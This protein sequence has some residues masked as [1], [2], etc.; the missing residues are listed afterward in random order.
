MWYRKQI[1]WLIVWLYYVITL[2]PV[3]GLVQIGDQAAAD[4]YTYLSMIPFYMLIGAGAGKFLSNQKEQKRLLP[5]FAIILVSVLVTV[6]LVALTRQ[7]SMVWRNDLVFWHYTALHAPGSGL[8]R[9]NYGRTLYDIGH[10]QEA[11]NEL[12]AAA[13]LRQ[14]ATINKWLGDAYFELGDLNKAKYYYATSFRLIADK[15]YV[16]TVEV[17]AQLAKI[18][19]KQGDTLLAQK[20]VDEALRLDPANSEARQLAVQLNTEK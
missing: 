13:E 5:T 4:R 17:F 16:N 11:I 9:G 12:K 2:L 14:S 18:A 1:Y 15:K 20:F 10:V 7:Q 6:S 8:V 3:I 19:V